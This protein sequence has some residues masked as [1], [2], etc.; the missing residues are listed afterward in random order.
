MYA[1]VLSVW[2]TKKPQSVQRTLHPVCDWD[3]LSVESSAK[4]FHNQAADNDT[5]YFYFKC[6]TEAKTFVFLLPSV[7]KVCLFLF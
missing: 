3:T 5:G 7:A 6:F 2:E 4:L 1:R